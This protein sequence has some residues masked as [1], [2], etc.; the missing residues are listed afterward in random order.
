[1]TQNKSRSGDL[2]AQL[3]C[4]IKMGIFLLRTYIEKNVRWKT[5]L[6]AFNKNKTMKREQK[7]LKKL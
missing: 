1:M 2:Q 3:I 4:N 7:N 6:R 5:D